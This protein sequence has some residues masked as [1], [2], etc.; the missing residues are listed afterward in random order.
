MKPALPDQR[1]LVGWALAR[2]ALRATKG[3]EDATTR[4]ECFRRS[5]AGGM[6]PQGRDHGR[7]RPGRRASGSGCRGGKRA[8]LARSGRHNEATLVLPQLAKSGNYGQDLQGICDA[9][10]Q[11]YS[12]VMSFARQVTR[13]RRRGQPAL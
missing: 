10:K 1:V 13:S 5:F 8:L 12:T 9:H 11:S 7:R 3:D 6:A 4:F 2:H